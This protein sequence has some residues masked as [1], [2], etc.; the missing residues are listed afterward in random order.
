M[1]YLI[2]FLCVYGPNL[3]A[4]CYKRDYSTEHLKK[5]PKQEVR[6]IQ[7]EQT[8]GYSE[9]E[10]SFDTFEIY[11][12]FDRNGKKILGHAKGR[13]EI[14]RSADAI[15]G[16]CRFESGKGALNL[17][18]RPG[19]EH[20]DESYLI[21][22]SPGAVLED[23]SYGQGEGAKTSISEYDST[24]LVHKDVEG[25]ILNDGRC[26]MVYAKAKHFVPAR[27]WNE[28]ILHSIRNDLARP[29]VTARNLF[30]LS[31]LLWDVGAAF[32]KNDQ[33]YFLK[34]KTDLNENLKPEAMSAAAYHFLKHRYKN[35]PANVG[36]IVPYWD[37]G[38]GK[39]DRY[40]DLFYDKIMAKLGHSVKG[41]QASDFGRS[42]ATKLLE[43]TLND[44]SRESEGYTSE[45]G[46][47][48]INKQILD[49]S[50]SGI[51]TPVK[52]VEVMYQDYFNYQEKGD[53]SSPFD[54]TPYRGQDF[55]KSLDLNH[56]VRLNIP[57]SVD[58]GGTAVASEQSPLTLF[59]GK[60][61]TF[62]D[63]S[64]FKSPT[65]E[66]VYFDSEI[67]LPNWQS[68]AEEVIKANL[69]VAEF[70]SLLNPVDLSEKDFDGDGSFDVNPGSEWIDISPARLGNNPLG[71]N[72][73]QG[74]AINPV[75]GKP[76]LPN[77]V[78]AANYYRSIAEFWADGPES[79]TPPGHWNTLANY[80]MDSL[81]GSGNG[82]R[83]MGQGEGLPEDLYAAKLYL[84]LN[85]ALH[86]A[87]VVAWGVKGHFQGNRPV[88]V[89]RA[90]AKRAEEDESF[91]R[92]LVAMSP[93]LKMVEYEKNG[94]LVRKLAIKSWRGP[95][96][97]AFYS[98]EIGQ[99]EFRDLSFR[100]Y[101]EKA[102][103]ENDFYREQGISGVGWILA[104][105][106]LP[107]Q[108]QTFVTPPF[109]G[110]VSGHSTFSRAAAEVLA[111]VTGSE[112]FPS[113]LC[114]YPAPN[115]HFESLLG[116]PFHFQWATYFD[117]S[118]ASG[119]SRLYGGIHASYDDLPA[120]V[121]GSKIGKKAVERAA[122][123]FSE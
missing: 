76:Y 97:G 20:Y 110:F 64:S 106:W 88:M 8:Y 54:L 23:L 67:H 52:D 5:H 60:L 15:T 81:K 102:I 82:F 85:G 77:L 94:V 42:M 89:I 13:C 79:E 44:G 45:P 32:S 27:L 72:E 101:S 65:K 117:A 48:L 74:R 33:G 118:D 112:Y 43:R 37:F 10:G 51:T 24:M 104:D 113:G 21:K 26:E 28:V 46:Y 99:I 61:P 75:T 123:F 29:T 109:P 68:D 12:D 30:H 91:A 90:L 55:S 17:E 92:R 62:G 105:N 63:L 39:E 71:T 56:W 69:Q 98:S 34:E 70:S 40:L 19:K 83:W 103:E 122:Q 14:S 96:R 95:F 119:I 49:I 121:I 53:Y 73:G 107:Y 111:G 47:Q 115:L 11:L 50:Q 3:Y 58:Q 114:E 78:K 31:A 6:Q 100:E 108:R 66:G 9:E 38:D 16:L 18:L 80:V 59:W 116:E 57:G 36:D 35:A 1:K 84:T 25:S 87:A 4:D 22:M 86:D 2:I 120:R 7:F 93:N 41:T